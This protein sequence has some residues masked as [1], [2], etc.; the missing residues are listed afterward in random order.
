[1][2]KI[3]DKIICIKKIEYYCDKTY[4][5][6]GDIFYVTDVFEHD[7]CIMENSNGQYYSLHY[8]I[9]N[10]LYGVYFIKE[11]EYRKQKLKTILG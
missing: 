4:T 11:S 7:G 1:M 10:G 5:N 6:I 2:F 9:P 3:G 8:S